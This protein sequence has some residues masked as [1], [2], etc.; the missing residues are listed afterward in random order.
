MTRRALIPVTDPT[1]IARAEERHTKV[2]LDAVLANRCAHASQMFGVAC[3][4]DCAHDGPHD[5]GVWQW[6]YCP[7]APYCLR[8]FDAAGGA[9]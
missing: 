7:A 4:R 5:N 1:R 9:P 2:V 6:G 3:T 8:P